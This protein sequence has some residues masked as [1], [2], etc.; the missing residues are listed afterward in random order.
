MCDLLLALPIV[1]GAN[2]R[3]MATVSDSDQSKQAIRSQIYAL[4]L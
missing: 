4:V 3:A 2:G 1:W